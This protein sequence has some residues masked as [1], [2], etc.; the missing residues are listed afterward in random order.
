MPSF[1]PVLILVLFFD[2]AGGGD[3][4]GG[5]RLSLDPDQWGEYG[6]NNASL[7]EG[8]FWEVM[9]EMHVSAPD[10]HRA[11]RT[12]KAFD[13]FS[14]IFTLKAKNKTT[15]HISSKDN[16]LGS[17]ESSRIHQL[18][19]LLKYTPLHPISHPHNEDFFWKWVKQKGIS[20][21]VL[22]DFRIKGK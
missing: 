16:I 20:T 10:G 17:Y 14:N 6:G 12:W 5:L 22:K 2:P 8:I 13:F 9:L 7:L 18:I 4:P 15:F 1:P 3:Q 19:I 11:E 21:E